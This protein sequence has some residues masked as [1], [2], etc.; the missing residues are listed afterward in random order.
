MTNI[1]ND[2]S[3]QGI[4]DSIED[5]SNSLSC[6]TPTNISIAGIIEGAAAAGA[7]ITNA[8]IQGIIT[9]LINFSCLPEHP[10]HI[11]QLDPFQQFKWEPLSPR[12]DVNTSQNKTI[13]RTVYAG[14]PHGLWGKL[15]EAA[16]HT[17]YPFYVLLVTLLFKKASNGEVIHR[18]SF[19]LISG[20]I[21]TY[22]LLT[23]GMFID[24]GFFTRWEDEVL[25]DATETGNRFA[26]SQ[27]TAE[28][29]YG[30]FPGL[31]RPVTGQGT[32]TGGLTLY[33]TNNGSPL[34]TTEKRLVFENSYTG[35]VEIES[36]IGASG[37]RADQD[38][39]LGNYV[40]LDLKDLYDQ[41][42]PGIRRDTYPC[43]TMTSTEDINALVLSDELE[44]QHNNQSTPM[45]PLDVMY[46]R[47]NDVIVHFY[48][49]YLWYQDSPT[50]WAYVK[51][52]N[53]GDKS[54]LTQYS[55]TVFITHQ[56]Y[57]P[58]LKATSGNVT[59]GVTPPNASI[60]H[61]R[62]VAYNLNS[63]SDGDSVRTYGV[64]AADRDDASNLEVMDPYKLLCY[65][66]A[67]GKY[68]YV[69]P[70]ET[71]PAGFQSNT[72]YGMHATGTTFD[73][74]IVDKSDGSFNNTSTSLVTLDIEGQGVVGANVFVLPSDHAAFPIQYSSA[75]NLYSSGLHGTHTTDLSFLL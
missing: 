11:V 37:V 63:M 19:P 40:N 12:I 26:Y 66:S 56:Y 53:I 45:H 61:P 39:D 1:F 17:T 33:R 67:A 34:H 44:L 2:K 71:P 35:T 46:L 16:I 49:Y 24:Q 28:H 62:G 5:P 21:G 42:V 52:G 8:S 4:I 73:V 43:T 74:H 36:Y 9:D 55:P 65:S 50:T 51:H 72:V 47:G 58:M 30:G 15:T 64:I 23:R 6:I 38:F 10:D 22:N 29:G 60:T 59:I 27:D 57:C 3:I 25:N 7:V 54:V 13:M 31:W 32:W 14:W 69:L 48:H 75:S 20:G 70:G 68:V 18:I 41:G